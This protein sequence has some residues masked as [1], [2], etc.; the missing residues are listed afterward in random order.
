M[1]E[2]LNK[3]N[4]E[5]RISLIQQTEHYTL[6]NT[7]PL[8]WNISSGYCFLALLSTVEKVKQSHYRPGVAQRVPGS[9]D[10]QFT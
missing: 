3:D 6:H 4:Q 7:L 2:P 10:S 8:L 9:Y 1:Q 5:I